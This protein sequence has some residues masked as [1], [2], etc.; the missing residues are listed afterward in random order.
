MD[1]RREPTT[2]PPLSLFPS[3][4]RLLKLSFHIA[5]LS[6]LERFTDHRTHSWTTRTSRSPVTPLACKIHRSTPAPTSTSHGRDRRHFIQAMQL[7]SQR[8][9]PAS[10]LTTC[11]LTRRHH[12]GLSMLSDGGRIPHYLSLT[13]LWRCLRGRTCSPLIV[14]RHSE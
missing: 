1:I 4:H 3:L 11:V 12:D 13:P 10:R 14:V 7:S 8:S 5:A 9:C 6:D 2:R